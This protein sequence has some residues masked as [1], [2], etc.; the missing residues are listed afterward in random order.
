MFAEKLWRA[1]LAGSPNDSSNQKNRDLDADYDDTLEESSQT[2]LR[3]TDI[4][5][6][7]QA[8][9]DRTTR[10]EVSSANRRFQGLSGPESD[11]RHQTGDQ[12]PRINDIGAQSYPEEDHPPQKS[13]KTNMTGSR[14]DLIDDP[15]ATSQVLSNPES[16]LWA[17]QEPVMNIL[18]FR[19]LSTKSHVGVVPNA[20]DKMRPRRRS[21][22]TATITIGPKTV[23]TVL[24]SQHLS[25]KEQS[26]SENVISSIAVS[27]RM[28]SFAAPGSSEIMPLNEKQPES[29][30]SSGGS[31]DSTHNSASSAMSDKSPI[32]KRTLSLDVETQEAESSEASVRDTNSLQ[33]S[34]G[35]EAEEND[36]DESREVG[37]GD[38]VAELI[39]RAEEKGKVL[40]I[41]TNRQAHH[42]L[43]GSNQRYQTHELSQIMQTSFSQVKEVFENTDHFKKDANHKQMSDHPL[44]SLLETPIPEARLSL[45]VSKEDFSRMHVIGQFNLGFVLATRDGKDLFIIDQ[46]ASDEKFNFERLQRTTVVQKQR[47]VHPRRLELTAVDEEVILENNEVLLQNGFDIDVDASG[48]YPV[49]QR[50]QLVSLPMS[51][52]VTFNTSDL[53]ELVSLLADDQTTYSGHVPRPGKIR[54]MFAMRACRSSIMIGKTLTKRQMEGIVR[55]MGEIDKPWN[56]PH[57]RPTMRHVCGL[58]NWNEWRE[59]DGMVGLEEEK[60][61]PIDWRE[62]MH[63]VK[64]EQ[65]EEHDEGHDHE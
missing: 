18:D 37:D 27:Q 36:S 19:N 4:N 11:V 15:P 48:A 61:E 10:F 23:S 30:G 34:N 32:R 63:R 16:L 26:K 12:N 8:F 62:W 20:F 44:E 33:G 57:G 59:G 40:Q 38:K 43:K 22:E 47:L 7:G 54:R 9:T 17:H 39:K 13:Q 49:G 45:V 51:K 35:S 5:L 14:S 25:R 29:V 1:D 64:Q 65:E 50:C 21:P 41:D 55:R 6:A 60:G 56:C 3:N 46:H 24:G 2:L 52:E 28:R 31:N 58:R 53:E 42:L